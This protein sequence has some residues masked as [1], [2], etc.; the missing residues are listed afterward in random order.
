M[1]HHCYI[2]KMQLKQIKSMMEYSSP[3]K[4]I[5]NVDF[6]ENF[7]I[8]Q[9]QEIMSGLWQSQAVTIYTAVINIQNSS[10]SSAVVSDE[11]HHDKYYVAAYNTAILDKSGAILLEKITVLHIVRDGT[12]NQFKNRF[13]V[14]NILRPNAI[15]PTLE[16]VERMLLATAQGKGSVDGVGGTVKLAV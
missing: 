4:A 7:N 14:S 2:A 15:H 13:T 9:Q 8:K 1:H 6:A 3:N 12:G 5:L 10:T 11:W 16:E